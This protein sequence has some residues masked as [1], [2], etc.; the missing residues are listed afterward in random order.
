M[1][2]LSWP[3]RKTKTKCVDTL[4]FVLFC[5][6]F[7]S[8][9][10]RDAVFFHLVDYLFFFS[11]FSLF[12]WILSFHVLSIFVWNT[13]NFSLL[14]HTLET[15]THAKKNCTGIPNFC[16]KIWIRYV[17][18][19]QKYVNIELNF[20]NFFCLISMIWRMIISNVRLYWLNQNGNHQNISPFTFGKSEMP[21]NF[22]S[23]R[24]SVDENVI[25]S[26]PSKKNRTLN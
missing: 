9:F 10:F 1:S 23:A 5:C 3:S 15:F 20:R 2:G 7:F 13:K 8:K 25:D 26:E 22:G 12:V 18:L 11:L 21:P 19:N 24:T 16:S 6:C 14:L 17:F 4:V